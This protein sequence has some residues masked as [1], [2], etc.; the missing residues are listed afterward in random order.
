MAME[1]E[2]VAKIA[3]LEEQKDVAGL[4]AIKD[5]ANA[6]FEGDI[7]G[8]AEQA[9][10]RLTGK[11]HEISA[12]SPTQIAQVEAM[13]GSADEI[14]HRTEAVNAQIKS[15]EA[16][17]EKQIN[18]VKGDG[19]EK[20]KEWNDEEYGKL[21]DQEA[22]NLTDGDLLNRSIYVYE[23]HDLPAGEKQAMAL[24]VYSWAERLTSAGVPFDAERVKKILD[25]N[26]STEYSSEDLNKGMVEKNPDQLA[27]EEARAEYDEKLK[28]YQEYYRQRDELG[29][30][31]EKIKTE[32]NYTADLAKLEQERNIDWLK[33]DIAMFP[34][35][36]TGLAN[37]N[38]IKAA[39][40]AEGNED[41]V[42]LLDDSIFK[43]S[44]MSDADI[45]LMNEQFIP[46][47]VRRYAHHLQGN[48]G[49]ITGSDSVGRAESKYK[50]D[51]ERQIKLDE[52]IATDSDLTEKVA[53]YNELGKGI[54]PRYEEFR[55]V[56]RKYEAA[57]KKVE[58]AGKA[59]SIQ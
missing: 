44:N 34:D 45:K 4:E 31:I 14:N 7:A 59:K 39:L 3:E 22:N 30:E 37:L 13:G 58:E 55:A 15:V 27:F 52:K 12:D 28:E 57:K 1:K 41:R 24:N 43:F 46:F 32:K 8:L 25:E 38:K 23:H 51:I 56:E 50:T 20:T 29:V 10:A 49:Q 36:A 5:E 19:S 2:A 16:E 17:T 21:T 48:F 11:A 26:P 40:Q 54:Q 18:E 35:K 53:K 9:I 47:N 6:T 33:I 42:K